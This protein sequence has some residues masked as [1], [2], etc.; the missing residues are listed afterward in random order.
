[1]TTT[2]TKNI[3]E[4]VSQINTLATAGSMIVR[5]AIFDMEDADAIK[6]Q[7]PKTV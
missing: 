5:L 6:I 2:K 3:D 7:F 4:T 1:M